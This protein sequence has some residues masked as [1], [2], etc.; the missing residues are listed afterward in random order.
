MDSVHILLIVRKRK[1]VA[2]LPA[3]WA[4]V[5]RARNTYGEVLSIF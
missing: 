5:A 1:K 2:T 3:S 4:S